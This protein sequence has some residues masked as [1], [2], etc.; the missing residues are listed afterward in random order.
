MCGRDFSMGRCMENVGFPWEVLDSSS[1]VRYIMIYFFLGDGKFFL[2]MF[3]GGSYTAPMEFCRH[4]CGVPSSLF[5]P[6]TTIL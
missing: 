2:D 6:R 3:S 4:R 5:E 1:S